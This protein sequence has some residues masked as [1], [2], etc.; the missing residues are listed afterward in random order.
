MQF[1]S[2][3]FNYIKFKFYYKIISKIAQEN[4]NN[5]IV[6]LVYCYEINAVLLEYDI[7]YGLINFFTK[8]H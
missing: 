1:I 2:Y 8:P 7:F 6:K 3:L 5:P 4:Q